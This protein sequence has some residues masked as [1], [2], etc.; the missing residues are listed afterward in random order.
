MILFL[1]AAFPLVRQLHFPY[2]RKEFS[3][4]VQCF[5]KKVTYTL[6]EHPRRVST[7]NINHVLSLS[8]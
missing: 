7:Y 3:F 6:M 1:L 4:K 8:L 2:M 5:K